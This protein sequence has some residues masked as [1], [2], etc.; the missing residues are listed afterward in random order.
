MS[1]SSVNGPTLY[2][3]ALTDQPEPVTRNKEIH[4]FGAR[5]TKPAAPAEAGGKTDHLNI[6]A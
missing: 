3:V 4:E 1:I 6:K 5:D 2:P